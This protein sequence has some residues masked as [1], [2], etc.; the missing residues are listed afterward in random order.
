MARSRRRML[1]MYSPD[2]AARNVELW[3]SISG[4]DETRRRMDLDRRS[5]ESWRAVEA[6]CFRLAAVETSRGRKWSATYHGRSAG[7][8]AA[9]YEARVAT[10]E[11][12][13]TVAA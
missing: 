11:R 7:I 5:A 4:A 12:L 2:E 1:A 8:R 6:T 10:A 3:H 9:Y 13:L